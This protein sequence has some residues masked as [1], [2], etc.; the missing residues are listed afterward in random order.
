MISPLLPESGQLESGHTA[1]AMDETLLLRCILA[2]ARLF[3]GSSAEAVLALFDAELDDALEA[4]ARRLERAIAGLSI[5]LALTLPNKDTQDLPRA[6]HLF[7]NA[8]HTLEKLRRGDYLHWAYLG[9]ALAFFC[10]AEHG[11]ASAKLKSSDELVSAVQDQIAQYW[12]HTLSVALETKQPVPFHKLFFLDTTTLQANSVASAHVFASEPMRRLIDECRLAANGTAPI[13]I[14]GERGAGKETVARVIHESQRRNIGPFEIVDCASVTDSWDAAAYLKHASQGEQPKTLFLDHVEHL[15]PS[16]QKALL[17]YLVEQES[18]SPDD[19]CLRIISASS[20]DLSDRVQKHTFNADLYH[21]LKICTLVLPPLRMRKQEI[22]VLAM[23]FSATLKP[24]GVSRVA[25]TE[26]ALSA[27]V[28]YDWPGN[29]RQL[30]NEIE[31]VLANVGFEP[32]PT[33]DLQSLSKAIRKKRKSPAVLPEFA[34]GPEYPLEDILSNTERSVIERVME[35]YQGQVSS[36]AQ[37]LGL[38]RQGL[39]KKLKRLGI[40]RSD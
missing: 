25:I 23:H 29:I 20:A 3:S 11:E 26:R 22:P 8:Q 39:Y 40:K 2:Q 28:E 19:Q 13:L 37:A 9:Q 12:F 36:A 15:G 31:R 18:C 16:Q 33:I 35:K 7:Q 10:L 4:P 21:R 14:A 17:S 24:K 32:L 6:L 27:L 34:E 5:G 38:T 30:K 1:S